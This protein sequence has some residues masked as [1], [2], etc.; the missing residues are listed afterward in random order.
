MRAPRAVAQREGGCA[1]GGSAR[2]KLASHGAA[3]AA[4]GHRWRLAVGEAAATGAKAGRERKRGGGSPHPRG[5]RRP[6]WKTRVAATTGD[7]E[8]RTGGGGTLGESREGLGE[9][10]TTTVA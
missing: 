10:A 8:A 7:A 9:E 4:R 2:L 5:R 6:A 1:A 3:A